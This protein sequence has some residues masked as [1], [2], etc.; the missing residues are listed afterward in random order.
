MIFLS[1]NKFY[2]SGNENS[3]F[4]VASLY[5]KRSLLCNPNFYVCNHMLRQSATYMLNI[6]YLVQQPTHAYKYS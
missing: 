5:T 1:L 4:Y 3:F 6:N 2:F